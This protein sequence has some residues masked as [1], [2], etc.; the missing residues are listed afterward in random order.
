MASP[1]DGVTIGDWV[2]YY[3]NSVLVIG[4]V[5][6]IHITLTGKTVFMTT[7]G[8]VDAGSVLEKK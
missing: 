5:E 8:S 2:R 6:Y 1:V 3:H 4:V 7:A